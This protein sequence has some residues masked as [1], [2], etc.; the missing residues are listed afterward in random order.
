MLILDLIPPTPR[1]PHGIHAVIW[2]TLRV[3]T[4]LPPEGQ[5]LTFVSY[6]AGPIKVAYVEPLAVGQ[7]L[8]SMPLFLET[9]WHV[10]VPL[11]ATYQN[12]WDGTP[13]YF[14]DILSNNSPQ[15]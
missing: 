12:A 3:G 8:P 1:D 15:S 14:R 10:P 13:A 4:F 5:P 7:A 9:G 11:E 6:E 2:E